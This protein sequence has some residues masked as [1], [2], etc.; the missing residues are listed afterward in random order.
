MTIHP[1]QL[2]RINI[3]EKNLPS[4]KKTYQ[5]QGKGFISMKNEISKK[6]KFYILYLLYLHT[7]YTV[8]LW[9]GAWA[10]T[11]GIGNRVGEVSSVQFKPV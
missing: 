8:H 11:K 2:E 9:E 1:F 3:Q 6:K 5:F 4:D 10:V 7:V